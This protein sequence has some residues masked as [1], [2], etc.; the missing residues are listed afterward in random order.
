MGTRFT[1][2]GSN[3]PPPKEIRV[4]SLQNRCSDF[5]QACNICKNNQIKKRSYFKAE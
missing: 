5:G 1:S 4:C 3:P 2:S